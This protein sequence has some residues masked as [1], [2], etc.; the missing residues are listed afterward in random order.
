MSN[1]D[2][3]GPSYMYNS[4]G[5]QVESKARTMPSIE[6]GSSLRPTLDEMTCENG[7]VI[8]QRRTH[9]DFYTIEARHVDCYKKKSTVS[10][11]PKI[12]YL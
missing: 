5:K 4:T 9:T 12:T 3:P 2:A 11:L 8:Q 1:K 6:F 10:N 7:K